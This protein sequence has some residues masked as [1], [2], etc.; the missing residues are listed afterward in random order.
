[1]L[2]NPT[3]WTWTTQTYWLRKRRARKQFGTM[4]LKQD[5]VNRSTQIVSSTTRRIQISL[6]LTL[7]VKANACH[8]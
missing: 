7:R 2:K 1:M 3:A 5:H 4:T 8:S 6:I